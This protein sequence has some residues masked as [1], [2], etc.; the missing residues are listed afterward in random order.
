ML[1]AS[2]RSLFVSC[3]QPCRFQFRKQG[4]KIRCESC[5]IRCDAVGLV[6]RDRKPRHRGPR[7]NFQ[8][9][10]NNPLIA[11]LFHVIL[12][13]IAHIAPPLSFLL[14]NFYS[15]RQNQLSVYA[16]SSNKSDLASDSIKLVESLK[17]TPLTICYPI[18]AEV[19][20]DNRLYRRS[21]SGHICRSIQ[22]AI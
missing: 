3:H 8:C 7:Q 17:Y 21:N 10:T 5:D 13:G 12:S 20:K 22:R 14:E 9:A 16:L 18:I 1:Y 19:S 11:A 15:L 6:F 2:F 4:I